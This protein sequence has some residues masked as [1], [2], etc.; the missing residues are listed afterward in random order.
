[1]L[2]PRLI[3]SVSEMPCMKCPYSGE[4]EKICER[5]PAWLNIKHYVAY[6]AMSFGKCSIY[7]A[8]NI[9]HMEKNKQTGKRRPKRRKR[10]GK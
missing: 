5:V 7:T 10:N 8:I 1:M 6:H 9:Q 4:C 2:S 3:K